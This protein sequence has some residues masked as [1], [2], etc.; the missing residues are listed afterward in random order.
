VDVVTAAFFVV[1]A[2]FVTAP[3]GAEAAVIAVQAITAVVKATL[4]ARRGMARRDGDSDT[5][6]PTVRLDGQPVQ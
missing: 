4:R 1:V 5:K 2:F 6:T 3:D